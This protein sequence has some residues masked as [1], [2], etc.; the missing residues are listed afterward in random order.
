MIL[1]KN[2]ALITASDGKLN[3]K[4]NMQMKLLKV[5]ELAETKEL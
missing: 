2:I 4:I 1:T 5:Q 3:D